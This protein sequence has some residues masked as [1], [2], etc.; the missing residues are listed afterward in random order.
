M[1]FYRT[2]NRNARNIYRKT[3]GREDH[4]GCMFTEQ[5]GRLVKQALNYHDLHSTTYAAPPAGE[6][7]DV[8]AVRLEA[9]LLPAVARE[10]AEQV[11]RDLTAN[12]FVVTAVDLGQ[13]GGG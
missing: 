3:P 2:G 11:L 5:D 4:I 12:D 1:T 6:V 9:Y 10:V 7:V 13:G 8:L